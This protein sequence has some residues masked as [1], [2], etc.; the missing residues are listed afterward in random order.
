[1]NRLASAILMPPTTSVAV[2]SSVDQKKPNTILYGI[3]I[4]ATVALVISSINNQFPE[5]D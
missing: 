4:L 5:E 2:V 1:M 3:L